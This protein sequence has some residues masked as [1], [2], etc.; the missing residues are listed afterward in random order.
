MLGETYEGR[1]GFFISFSRRLGSYEWSGN[2]VI[3]FIQARSGR[4]N[5]GDGDRGCEFQKIEAG[6][7]VWRLSVYMVDRN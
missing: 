3:L 6:L 4:C 2:L 5:R 1:D 7:Q